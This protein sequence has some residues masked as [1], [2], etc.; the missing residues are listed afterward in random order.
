MKK[1]EKIAQK[2]GYVD[3][4]HLEVNISSFGDPLNLWWDVIKEFVE[5]DKN[6]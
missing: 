5:E 1:L 3:V 2:L 4:E 6:K